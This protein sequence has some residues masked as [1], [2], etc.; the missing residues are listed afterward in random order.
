MNG[1]KTDPDNIDAGAAFGDVDVG[2]GG[3]DDDDHADDDGGSEDDVCVC[4][5][6]CGQLWFVSQVFWLIDVSF[7]AVMYG[8][9]VCSDLCRD[10]FST[11]KSGDRC[12]CCASDRFRCS[13]YHHVRSNFTHWSAEGA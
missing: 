10:C 11:R 8:K 13:C 12:C 3:D 9:S 7:C 2:S 4:V 1:L 5:H 6:G